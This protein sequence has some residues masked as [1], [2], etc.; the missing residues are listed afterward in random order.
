VGFVGED[1]GGGLGHHQPEHGAAVL[2]P[3]VDSSAQGAALAG[4]GG[5]DE[6]PDSL[7]VAEPVLRAGGVEPA[8][9]H[10]GCAG[11]AGG[12]E[13]PRFLVEQV[14]Q[15]EPLPRGTGVGGG[16]VAR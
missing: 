14:G 2:A 5:S 12:L 13:Q 8:G 16:P 3:G 6:Q 10:G 7:V 4:A 15:G 11:V 9:W 1:L